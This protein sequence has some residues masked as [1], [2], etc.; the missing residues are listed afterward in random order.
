M[1]SIFTA[2]YTFVSTNKCNFVSIKLLHNQLLQLN[3]F[4]DSFHLGILFF[5][6]KIKCICSGIYCEMT[7]GVTKSTKAIKTN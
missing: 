1:S 7:L 2:E 3:Y 4:P 5:M 6:V